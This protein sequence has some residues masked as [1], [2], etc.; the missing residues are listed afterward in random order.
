MVKL[1]RLRGKEGVLVEDPWHDDDSVWKDIEPVIFSREKLGDASDEVDRIASLARISPAARVLDLCC[2]V[3]RHSIQLALRGFE[4]TA[5]DRTSRYLDRAAESAREAGVEVEFVLDDMRDFRRNE[6]F[7]SILNLFTS[8]G[9]FEN[10][11]D[12]LEVLRNVAASLKPGGSFV[13]DVMGKEVLARIFQERR[14]EE[15]DGFV[16]LQSSRVERNWSWVR[17]R[18]TVLGEEGRRQIE[19]RHRVYSAVELCSLI[20]ESGLGVAGVYGNLEGAPYDHE[21]ERL[22]VVAGKPDG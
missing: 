10:P 22:V 1:S 9:Y 21:S 7:D 4:V 14:W 2:G 19:V 15:R 8:F 5:V 16:L 18:W 11:L 12:D 6:F 17:S 13:I 3:G 20:E